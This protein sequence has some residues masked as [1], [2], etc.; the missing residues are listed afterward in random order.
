MHDMHDS[1]VGDFLKKLLQRD[2]SWSVLG[3]SARNGLVEQ[4]SFFLRSERKERS[5]S[6]FSVDGA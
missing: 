5:S 1:V 6:L 3:R 4:L 2:G